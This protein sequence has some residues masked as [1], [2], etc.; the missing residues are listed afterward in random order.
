MLYGWKD[1]GLY[2][3]RILVLKGVVRSTHV[4]PGCRGWVGGS[5][6]V[7]G[8]GDKIKHDIGIIA[9]FSLFIGYGTF[10]RIPNGVE[11]AIGGA[12]GGGWVCIEFSRGSVKSKALGRG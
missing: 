11:D 10:S 9:V 2:R 4:M 1:H 3:A 8:G 6:V 7:V 5:R 12:G